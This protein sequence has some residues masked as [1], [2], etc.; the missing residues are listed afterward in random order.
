M[1]SQPLMNGSDVTILQNL[2][3]RFASLPLSGLYDASTAAVVQSYQQS[4]KM[5]PTGEVDA[6]TANAILAAF[7]QDGMLID[8]I[9]AKP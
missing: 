9:N 6:T 3:A 8:N 1:V 4:I 7:S 5:Q 2:I